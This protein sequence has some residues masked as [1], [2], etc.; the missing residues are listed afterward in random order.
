MNI[1]NRQ[2]HNYKYYLDDPVPLELEQRLDEIIKACPIQ[3]SPCEKVQIYKTTQDDKDIKELLSYAVF[4]NI[5][6]P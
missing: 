1:W 5:D 3:R 6:V 4:K 2:R